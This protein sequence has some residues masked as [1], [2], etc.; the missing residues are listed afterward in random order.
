MKYSIIL[1]CFVY[2]CGNPSKDM[3]SENKEAI[4]SV[5]FKQQEAWN[6]GNLEQFMEGYW[7]SD[8]LTFIGRNGLKN[9]W[10]NTLENYKKSYPDLDAMGKLNFEILD[11]DV[12]GPESAVMTG[13]YTLERKSDKPTG[14]FLLIWKLKNKMWVI[15]TD[16]TCG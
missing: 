14:L 4:K 2:A 13:R 7:R 10:Q 1:V 12:L 15:T 9:G 11:L 8:S 6:A 3:S 5:L 16:Q